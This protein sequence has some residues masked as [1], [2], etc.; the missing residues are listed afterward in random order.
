MGQER[1]LRGVCAAGNTV[2]V[3]LLSTVAGIGGLCGDENDIHKGA[4][5]ERKIL[6]T[7]WVEMSDKPKKKKI[8]GRK[9]HVYE[10]V[11]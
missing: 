2:T 3:R 4:R 6:R 7:I 10:V 11:T 5:K 8:L 1:R 9:S